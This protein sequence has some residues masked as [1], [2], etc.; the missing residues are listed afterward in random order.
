MAEAISDDTAQAVISLWKSDRVLSGLTAR[1]PQWDRLEAQGMPNVE[2]MIKRER[3]EVAA[4]G[5]PP[6]W[7]DFRRVE[8]MVRGLKADVKTIVAETRRVFLH[9][10]Q[11][12]YPSG[13]Q[14]MAVIPDNDADME[15]DENNKDGAEVWKGTIS[16][17]CESVRV[18]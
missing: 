17:L 4:S 18:G 16:F 8:L 6:V 15:K 2:M 7:F 5:T 14:C 10:T 11:L 12:V 3:R 9:G 1:P 13:A